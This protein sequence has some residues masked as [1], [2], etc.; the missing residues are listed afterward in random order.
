MAVQHQRP[1]VRGCEGGGTR[2]QYCLRVGTRVPA[3]P[4]PSLVA[5]LVV[6]LLLL[7][8]LLLAL[9]VLLVVLLVMAA[10]NEQ[11][12]AACSVRCYFGFCF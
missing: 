11:A 2:W 7:V 6:V 9:L 8:L 1:E 4:P 5:P 12:G 10:V 3:A